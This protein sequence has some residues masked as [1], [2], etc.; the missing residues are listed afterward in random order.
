MWDIQIPNQQNSGFL[1]Q[2][3][4]SRRSGRSR[5]FTVIRWQSFV[6]EEQELQGEPQNCKVP[7]FALDFRPLQT[8]QYC[9]CKNLCNCHILTFTSLASDSSITSNV[10]NLSCF[11][12]KN[13]TFYTDIQSLRGKLA[14]NLCT[15]S[16]FWATFSCIYEMRLICLL[17]DHRF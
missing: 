12:Q 17:Q 2:L 11:I 3:A 6:K 15:L 4:V 5:S 7:N 14:M 1:A 10:Q 8:L 9:S 13:L 16:A